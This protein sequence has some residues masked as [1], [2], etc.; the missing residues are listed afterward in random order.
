M[1]SAEE[2]PVRAQAPRRVGGGIG[3][4][5]LVSA[6]IVASDQVTKQSVIDNLALY[7]RIQILPVMDLV[8]L[9]N[10]GA[11]FNFLAGASGWQNWFFVG[12]AVAVGAGILVWMTRVPRS[13][14]VTLLLG[15]SMI[16]GGAIGNLIDRLLY[17]YVIDFILFYYRSWSYPAFNLADAAITCGAVLVLIDGLVLERR[18][19]PV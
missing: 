9:H 18:R 14:H 16:F 10:T 4:W 1:N 12:V 3:W 6:L 13:G 2:I 8:R 19:Q 15:L 7:Q 5:L 11:A 17:G